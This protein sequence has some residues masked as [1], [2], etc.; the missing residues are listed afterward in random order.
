MPV[1]LDRGMT[2]PATKLKDHKLLIVSLMPRAKSLLSGPKSEEVWPRESKW[3]CC[4][5][6][7]EVELAASHTTTSRRE[8][9]WSILYS[10]RITGNTT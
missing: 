2:D 10:G 7:L 9:A 5:G 4:A 6:Y 8:V 3:S 1:T